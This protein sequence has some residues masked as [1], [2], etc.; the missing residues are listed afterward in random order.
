MQN[1]WPSFT[2][3]TGT[4][5]RHF[6]RLFVLLGCLLPFSGAYGQY[7]YTLTINPTYNVMTSGTAIPLDFAGIGF[8][9]ESVVSGQFGVSGN[10]FSTSDTSLLTIFQN[11]G[12]RNIRVGGGTVDGCTRYTPASSDISNLFT[13]AASANL[14]V[15]YSLPL[16]NPTSCANSSL[17]TNDG[18]TAQ[19]IMSSYAANLHSFALGNEPDWHSYHSYCDTASSDCSCPYPG[20]CSVTGTGTDSINDPLMY[21]MFDPCS[22]TSGT[23][24]T[25]I[26]GD[27]W[28]PGTAFTSYLSDWTSFASTVTSSVTSGTPLFSGPDQGDYSDG[29]TYTGE[30]ATC[31]DDSFT[32]GTWTQM[33]YTCEEALNPSQFSL[34]TQHLYVGGGLGYLT[35]SAALE[36]MLSAVWVTE[37]SPSYEPFGTSSPCRT[38][39]EPSGDNCPS[40]YAPYPWMKTLIPTGTRLTESND[41]LGGSNGASN[42][43]GS[44]LWALDYMQWWAANGA[45]GVNFHNNPWLYTDT[46]VPSNVEWS[47]S[48]TTCNGTCSTTIEL[49]PKGYGIKMFDLG[50]HGYSI[51]TSP[52]TDSSYVDSFAVGSAQDLYVTIVNRSNSIY[53]NDETADVTIDL[54][55]GSGTSLPFA[56]ASVASIALTDVTGGGEGNVSTQDWTSTTVGGANITGSGPFY[57]EWTSLSAYT[58]GTYSVSV[59]ASTATV[60]HFRAPSY[61]AGPIQINQDGALE[62]F[63]TSSGVVHHNYQQKAKEPASAPSNWNAS[64][65]TA[66]PSL[67]GVT[68]TGAPAV[69]KNNDNTLEIF[70][71][72]SGDVWHNWQVA[73]GAGWNGWV[74]MGSGSSGLTDIQVGEGAN[75]DL[76]VF[77]IN[78]SGAMYYSRET[79][80]R[81]GWSSW[82]ELG[83]SLS[84][85]VKAGYVV[86]QNLSGRVELFAADGSSSPQIW[87]AWQT[88]SGPF[89]AS[90]TALTTGG[91]TVSSPQ[92]AV[93]RNLS[94]ILEVFGIGTDGHVWH[95]TQASAGAGPWSTWAELESGTQI[96]I[97]PGFAVGQNDSGDLVVYGVSGTGSSAQVYYN[98]QSS[99][100]GSYASSWTEIAMPSGDYAGSNQIVVSSTA[101]GRMQLFTTG[102]NG[103]VW[104][105]W[106]TAA[107]GSGNWNGW[108]DFGSGSDGET[109]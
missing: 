97:Q 62:M 81:A 21:E 102:S 54:T 51:A 53:G 10:F 60:Y 6:W 99:P 92:L 77:G 15:I 28:E 17:A 22:N 91:A 68:A 37:T 41:F 44:A 78:S 25:F 55:T 71:P 34:P 56:A 52:Q 65:S 107:G 70:V 90:W 98:A 69:I 26:S 18:T 2:V 9:T 106:Q 49:N 89:N 101:D 88:S 72:T 23:S 85:G 31:S 80:P 87:H 58:G 84:G 61:Y 48:E 3:K 103:D 45:V 108:S 59:P 79:G 24:C 1:Q 11:L 67:T 38:Y 105:N 32:G 40:G 86:T 66:W 4:W 47:S 12:L 95:S 13:F 109:F 29:T 8:E 14:K 16:I 94:G 83:G 75:G 5:R 63:A 104:T 93:A 42:A 39:P 96:A 46:V 36:N 76:S 27:G 43:F 19:S 100:G 20:G 73:P 82:A 33:L 30:V 50:G 74:D 57:G 7:S 35:S 64:S